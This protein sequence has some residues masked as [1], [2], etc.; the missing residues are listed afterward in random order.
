MEKNITLINFDHV[1]TFYCLFDHVVTATWTSWQLN[2]GPKKK[3]VLQV[4]LFFNDS[5][6]GSFASLKRTI[7]CS[8]AFFCIHIVHIVLTFSSTIL[9]HWL[10]SSMWSCTVIPV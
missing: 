2:L 3:E 1:V 5:W 6:K 8:T 10:Y 7:C 9:L 4:P